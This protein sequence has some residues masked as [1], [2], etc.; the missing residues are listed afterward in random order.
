MGSIEKIQSEIVKEFEMFDNWMEKY[1]YIIELG[2]D[3]PE[4]NPIHKTEKNLIK[5]CQSRVWLYAEEKNNIISF[6]ADSDA[7]I[8]KGIVAI[9]V[10]VLSNQTAKAIIKSDLTFID[11]I[12][13]KEQLSQ[14][15]ANG[16]ISMVKA[17]KVYA[18]AFNK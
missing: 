5:G 11:K 10:R 3:L 18:L 8:T 15:R 4:I 6:S 2:K 13:F 1:E 9:L 7:I 17:M 12:G 14:T 16:L